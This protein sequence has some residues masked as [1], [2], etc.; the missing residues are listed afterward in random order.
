MYY[1][2]FVPLYLL[3]LLPWWVLYRLSD[4][5]FFIVY[6]L[7]GYRKDVVL[8]N[9]SHA[10]PEKTVDELKRIRRN[11]YRNFCDNWIETIKLISVSEKALLSRVSGD[12]TLFEE[13]Y[14]T[15]R[16]MQ[17]NFGHF[18]NW[19]MLGQ[20]YIIRFP[21]TILG[22]YFPQKSKNMDRLLKF[23]RGKR[24]NVLV[25]MPEMARHIIPWRR[26]QYFMAL[27]GDQSPAIP[28]TSYWLYF[29][30]RPACFVKGPEKFARGQKIPVSFTYTYKPRRGHY[31]FESV[32]LADDPLALPEGELMRRYVRAIEDNIRRAPELY[33]W[34]HKR[35]KH[36]WRPEYIEHWV[37][38][39]PPPR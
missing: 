1:L 24:G 4:F 7:I 31:H 23:I 3:S 28:E 12:V 25:P 9:L 19:E 6:H 29:M 27:I 16:S 2:V 39:A 37:D 18:F 22:V 20:Y 11:N 38:D 14:K 17:G 30:N 35:W 36:G 26:K 21:Y 33:M 8:Q 10:F 32:L 15:G 13:M 5:A 34:T